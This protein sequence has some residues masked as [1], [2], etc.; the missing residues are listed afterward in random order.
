MFIESLFENQPKPTSIFEQD[1]NNSFFSSNFSKL[2]N[3]KT[4]PGKNIWFLK[5][6]DFYYI[7]FFLLIVLNSEPDWSPPVSAI[8]PPIPDV[9]PQV[10]TSEDWQAAFGFSNSN[11]SRN[12]YLSS[13]INRTMVNYLIMYFNYVITNRCL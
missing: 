13:D 7:I 8:L 1:N 4:S 5:T 6:L 9:L 2:T 3:G 12:N 10:Q 11:N